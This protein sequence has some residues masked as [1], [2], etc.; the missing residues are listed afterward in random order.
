MAVAKYR[1]PSLPSTFHV[2]PAQIDGTWR[3]ADP[4]YDDNRLMIIDALTVRLRRYERALVLRAL[5]DSQGA[6]QPASRALGLSH[7]ST[8]RYRI[9]RLGLADDLAELRQARKP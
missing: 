6:V 9:A 8:L 5:R 7:E 3:A 2:E 4:T 1:G